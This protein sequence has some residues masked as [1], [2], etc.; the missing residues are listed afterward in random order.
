MTGSSHLGVDKRAQEPGQTLVTVPSVKQRRAAEDA[1]TYLSEAR[2]RVERWSFLPPLLTG[3]RLVTSPKPSE[4]HWT[5]SLA[6]Q[7]EWQPKSDSGRST[8]CA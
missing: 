5:P 3:S 2:H 7:T 8:R 4:S 6:M 1:V